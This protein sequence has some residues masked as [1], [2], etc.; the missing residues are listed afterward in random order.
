MNQTFKALADKTRREILKLLSE[1]DMS[2][3][4]IS[5]YFSI[6]K[7]S[8]SHHLGV[9]KNANLVSAERCGQEIIYSLNLTVFQELTAAFFDLFERRKDAQ[10]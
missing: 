2:A 8:I 1:K 4:E 10:N 6:S 3:G 7:P 9:L 5:G